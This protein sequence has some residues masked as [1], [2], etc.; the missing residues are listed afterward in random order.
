[1]THRTNNSLEYTFICG[2]WIFS[3]GSKIFLNVLRVFEILVFRKFFFAQDTRCDQTLFIRFS[4]SQFSKLSVL[5]RICP[6]NYYL[7]QILHRL[8]FPLI[9]H[10][11]R[12]STSFYMFHLMD[13]GI[14][15]YPIVRLLRNS[16]YG[17]N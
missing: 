3:I 11:T 5:R 14:Y 12:Q 4:K 8:L 15:V 9:F 13:N 1:M 7:F 6:V 2:N 16:L 10:L 17:R